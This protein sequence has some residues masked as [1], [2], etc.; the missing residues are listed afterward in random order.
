MSNRFDAWSQWKPYSCRSHQLP[1]SKLANFKSNQLDVP[2]LTYARDF[3][4]ESEE[5]A[6]IAE[7]NRNDW[8]GD[9]SRRVQH[10]GWRYN[11]KGKAGRPLELP[12]SPAE[13]G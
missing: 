3:L 5:A 11:Y 1:R 6:L 10:Y 9:L 4:S 8:I 7:I 12:W 2:G 13:M